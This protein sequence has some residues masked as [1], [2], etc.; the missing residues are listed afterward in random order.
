[1][2]VFA[3]YNSIILKLWRL[4]DDGFLIRWFITKQKRNCIVATW[5]PRWTCSLSQAWQRLSVWCHQPKSLHLAAFPFTAINAATLARHISNPTS[6]HKRV[7]QGTGQHCPLSLLEMQYTEPTPLAE[8]H[9]GTKDSLA[10]PINVLIFQD[11]H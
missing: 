8:D 3:D 5:L 9:Q 4:K 1:M 7:L 11:T 6:H 10:P 2:F